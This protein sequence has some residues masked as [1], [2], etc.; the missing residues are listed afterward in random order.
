MTVEEAVRG[1]LAATAGVTTLVGQRVYQLRLPQNFTPP[2]VRIHLISEP[3]D[4]H[5]RGPNNTTRSR[6]QVDS[7]DVESSGTDPYADAN[8]VATA[9]DDAL[10][11][12]PFTY[13]GFE[14]TGSFRINR[15]AMYESEE[16]RLVR[17]IQDYYVWSH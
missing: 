4:Y 13:S 6:V 5:L 2:A 12:V 9:V 14:V 3:K 11:G 1:Y 17:I 8:A 7:I 10:S 15:M 16:L